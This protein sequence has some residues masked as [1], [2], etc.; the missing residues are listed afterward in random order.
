MHGFGTQPKSGQIRR[1]AI[2]PGWDKALSVCNSIVLRLI[3]IG[4][5]AGLLAALVPTWACAI[6]IEVKSRQ[7][8]RDILALYDSRHEPNA[9]NTRIHRMAEMPLNWLGYKLTYRDVN[10][11]LP[12]VAELQSYRGIVTWLVEPMGHAPDYVRWLDEVTAAG[13]RLVVLGDVAPGDAS[14]ADATTLRVY[15]RIGLKLSDQFVAVTHTST[16]AFADNAMIGFERPLDKAL[17]PFPVLTPST[18]ATRVHLSLTLPGESSAS[19][20]AVVTTSSG[21]GYA[22]E[23]FT[24]YYEPV[25]DRVRWVLNPFKF[26]KSALGDDLFPVPDVTTLDGRRMYFSHIDGDGW[27]NISE[28]ENYREAQTVAADVVRQEIIEPYPDLPVSVGLIAGD[29]LPELGGMKAAQESA[30]RVFKL[31]QVEVAS[32]TYTHPF[33]WGF[34]EQYDRAKE[35]DLVEKV[36]RPSPAIADRFRAFL[37]QVA[38]KGDLGD[39]RGKYVAGSSDLPRSYLKEPFDIEKEVKDALHISEALAPAGKKATIYLWS[40]DTEPFEA[41][42]RATRNAGVRNMNGGDTRL[43]A[44]YPSHFYVPPISRPV[45]AERQI[46]AGNS[47]E[48]TYTNNWHGPFFGQAM[49]KETLAN[50]ESPRR[51]KPFNLYYHMYS[52]EKPGAVT[53]LKG[54]LDI[55]RASSV[56]PVKAS[57]YAAIADDFFAAELEE[58]GRLSWRVTK[59]GNMQTFR[60]D[61]ASGVDLDWV[62]SA[63]VLG[64]NRVNDALYV[65]LDPA[66][67]EATITLR[68]REAGEPTMPPASALVESRWQVSSLQQAGAGACG[69]SASAH[70]FGTGD[71]IWQTRPG[72]AFHV[73]ASRGGTLLFEGQSTSDASGR[74]ST[75]IAVDAVDEPVLLHFDCGGGAQ[76]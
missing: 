36:S 7:V 16:V 27:N 24:I 3:R 17:P 58:A 45:G 6:E 38:G 23:G 22:A 30:R 49:L 50:T 60:F 74:L 28:I 62:H 9:P 66:A 41:A 75:S 71:M 32:H 35:L 43:D 5:L 48:N 14:T 55:A 37:Y 20:S 12:S 31:P 57:E 40:G 21:G 26:F 33:A 51:L 10:A 64:T 39:G 18:S 52:G 53:A 1:V 65:A 56:I 69:F 19:Q 61:A 34:F 76:P 72:T 73:T 13:L 2:A 15:E 46:Y 4:A 44:E 29:A 54:L 59:R 70:G 42:I 68:P 63:G 8:R 11:P 67:G 47:N 25:S